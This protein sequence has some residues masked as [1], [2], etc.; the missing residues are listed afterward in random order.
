[1]AYEFTGHPLYS[2]Y[3]LGGGGNSAQLPLVES[4]HECTVIIATTI[5]FVACKDG[6]LCT[7]LSNGYG[8]P[9]ITYMSTAQLSYMLSGMKCVKSLGLLVITDNLEE[10]M[11]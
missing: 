4:M 9:I 2:H 7:F 3:S 5:L 8:T 10:P 6:F 11:L 1:M